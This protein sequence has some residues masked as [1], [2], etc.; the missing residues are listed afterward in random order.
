MVREIFNL[1]TNNISKNI[2]FMNKEMLK[3]KKIVS[4]TKQIILG[5]NFCYHITM[6]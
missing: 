2:F 5:Y 1:A 3:I 6:I 4:E